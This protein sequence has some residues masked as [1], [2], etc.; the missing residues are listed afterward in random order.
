M[1]THWSGV[2]PAATTEFH[3]DQ[4]LDIPGTLAHLDK[5]I[6]AGIDGLIM[7]GTV[8]ENCSL[9]GAEKREVLK[10]TVKRVA[11]RER[12]PAPVLTQTGSP[13]SAAISRR[14][15]RMSVKASTRKGVSPRS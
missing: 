10:A 15:S 3:S 2:F 14:V 12:I 7:L 6:D 11:G 1:S 13:H 4:T 9:S 8:G 5:M